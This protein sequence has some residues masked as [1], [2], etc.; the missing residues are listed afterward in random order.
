MRPR[1]AYIPLMLRMR[2]LMIKPDRLDA[3]SRHTSPQRETAPAH[4]DTKAAVMAPVKSVS[5]IA[6]YCQHQMLLLQKLV[7]QGKVKYLGL[8]EATADEIRRA[9]AIHP[10]SAVQLEWSL[11]T[12]NAEVRILVLQHPY[13]AVCHRPT[14]CDSVSVTLHLLCLRLFRH[15]KV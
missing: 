1:P 11:W 3:S 6:G 15:N 8:S 4:S 5:L 12:R 2:N 7:E 13:L 9:H 14:E 10:I